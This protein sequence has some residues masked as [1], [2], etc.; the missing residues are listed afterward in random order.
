MKIAYFM[1]GLL[2]TTA[3]LAEAKKTVCSMAINS[4]DEINAFKSE[5]SPNDFDFVELTKNKSDGGD[6]FKNS[7][8]AKVQCDVLIISG[9]FAGTFF[10]ESGMNL[11][12][13]DLENASCKSDCDGI[14]KRPKEVFLFGCNTLAGKKADQR[15]PE[16][17]L[18][19]LM[20]DGFSAAQA[21]QVV[22]FR[23][24]PIGGRFSYR[25][26]QIF[27]KTPRIY[28]FNS[29]SPLG[30]YNGPILKTY[31]RQN[32]SNYVQIVESATSAQNMSLLKA[33]SRTAIV[34]ETGAAV[35]TNETSPVCYLSSENQS[36]SRIDKLKWIQAQLEKSDSLELV[37]HFTEFFKEQKFQRRW[38]NEE[39]AIFS[40]IQENSAL[41]EQLTAIVSS[42]KLWLKRTQAE[43][44][45]FMK[46]VGWID[47]KS[48]SHQIVQIL[49]LNKPNMTQ[50]EMMYACG[51]KIQADLEMS[52]LDQN[53]FNNPNFRY[54]VSCVNQKPGAVSSKIS[55]YDRN[56]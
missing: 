28:G 32:S 3:S 31:L 25:M 39:A 48:Y 23:Y 54:A 7:C 38:T 26:S 2:L 35:A 27:N 33:F 52:D 41:K 55:S 53:Q 40:K 50:E 9:H 17:Y 1:L 30:K 6:W 44:L 21:Q 34:Q 56:Y 37:G 46:Q 45:E 51:M 22:A 5:L 10:G 15:T 43:V 36:T 47:S 18:E 20:N 8:A 19:V 4:S 24:S 13:N 42:N 11:P 49:N 14:L 29:V 12:I 16:Q